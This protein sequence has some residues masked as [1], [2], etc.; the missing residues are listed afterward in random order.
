MIFT[1]QYKTFNDWLG[2][3]LHIAASCDNDQ[4]CKYDI[5]H[6][7]HQGRPILF[8]EIHHPV[9]HVRLFYSDAHKGLW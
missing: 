8:L 1:E 4:Y 5:L 3:H 2:D 7:M 6:D 9:Q